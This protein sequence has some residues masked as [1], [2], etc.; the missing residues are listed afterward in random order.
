ML[1]E[2]LKVAGTKST[3]YKMLSL[4]EFKPSAGG[5][6]DKPQPAATLRLSRI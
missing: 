5:N 4:A 6:F 1:H 2:I 3:N